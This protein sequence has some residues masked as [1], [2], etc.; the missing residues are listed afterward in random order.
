MNH[1]IAVA[2]KGRAL[3]ALL[4][5]VALLALLAL[6]RQTPALAYDVCAP[7]GSSCVHE[8][9]ADQAR[10]L[11]TDAAVKSEIDTY[12]EDIKGG[13]THED[14]FDHVYGLNLKVVIIG[15][16]LVTA[17]HFWDADAGPEAAAENADRYALGEF[18]NS[19]QKVRAL[20]DL[21]LGAYADGN[22]PLAYHYLGHIVHHIEDNTVPAHVHDDP[23]PNLLGGLDDDSYHVW[24]DDPGADANAPQHAALDSDEKAYLKVLGPLPFSKLDPD[25]LH[26]LLYSTNQVADHFASDDYNGD[27]NDPLGIMGGELAALPDKPVHRDQLSDND[28]CLTGSDADVICPG[29]NNNDDGDLSVIRLFSYMRGIRAVSSL[30]SLFEEA[31]K[32][33][34]SLVVVIDR[35]EENQNGEGLDESCTTVLGEDVCAPYPISDDP[36]YYARVSINGYES[37]NRGDRID[38]Q[39]TINPHWV[40]ANNVGLTGTAPVQIGIWDHDGLYDDIA[41]TRGGDDQSDIDSNG[42]TGDQTLDLN[43]DLEKCL[44]GDPGAVT[45]DDISIACGQQWSQEG[46]ADE[47]ESK[48]FFHIFM[49]AH[50]PT[51][52]AGGPYTTKEGTNVALDG[53]G[54]TDPDNNITVYHWDLDGD[55]HCEEG[56][57][58]STPDFTAVGQDGTTTVKLCVTDATGLTS[59]DTTTVTVT[60]E[61]PLIAVSSDSPRNE[62]TEVTVS[63]SVTDPGWLDSLSATI[64]WGDGAGSAPL[65]G[66]TENN[67]PDATLAF[68]IKH[69]Y[70]DNG[71]FIVKVCARDDDTNPCTSFNVQVNNTAPTATIDLSGAVS[72]NGTLTIIAHAGQALPFSGRSTDPGSDDLALRWSWGDGTP[73]SELPSLVNPPSSDP[74]ISPSIQPRDVTYPQTH[75]FSGACAYSTTFTATDD[76]LGTASQAA[77]VIILGNSNQTRLVG[78]WK[79][80]FQHYVTGKRPLPD[81]S[82]GELGCYVRIVSYMSR[83]FDETNDA[84]TF[85]RAQDILDTS[86]TSAIRELFDQ[87]LLAIWLNFANGAMPWDQ[88]VDTNGDKVPDTRFLDAM[89]AAENLRLDPNATR[90]QLDRQKRLL[91][92]W[93]GAK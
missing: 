46:D 18:P 39:T 58:D 60:N 85:A 17:T 63:G 89:S 41:T 79:Q 70:G 51:A 10:P 88:L 33:Q 59:E 44:R 68:S 74:P 72:V 43:V 25:R 80:Q 54:S 69:T 86:K 55:G 2:R 1:E 67:R 93:T 12:W 24:M 32:N 75:T 83:V 27:D 64:D 21:A 76:D 87:Q 71:T 5:N 19:W 82:A 26:W 9:M 66:T 52:D 40:F 6:S 15:E 16:P 3:V 53:T 81:F 29:A 35:V 11:I 61:A 65:T 42:G 84:S 23:H 31:T 34:V 90:D 49:T 47:H 38:E 50:P 57:S 45:G 8:Y 73:P 4:L 20:W 36:D 62:N 13:I 78:Y 30:Y 14:S 48:V 92:T 28:G 37:R 7:V 22:K 91:E 77:A 56:P